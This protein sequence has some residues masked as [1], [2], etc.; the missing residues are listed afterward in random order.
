[1]KKLKFV[2][3][4]VFL[5][6]IMSANLIAQQTESQTKA[7]PKELRARLELYWK[8]FINEDWEKLFEMT[9]LSKSDQNKEYHIAQWKTQLTYRIKEKEDSITE[10]RLEE[11][12]ELTSFGY[13]ILGCTKIKDED[14]NENWFWNQS[15]VLK[16]EDN[17]WLVRSGSVLSVFLK[18]GSFKPCDKDISLLPIKIEGK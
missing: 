1:M 10:V 13:V 6:L 7:V 4:L 14:G 12:M 18:D 15:I 11:K 2:P 5:T 17:E 8:Y 3:G 16:N 9:T